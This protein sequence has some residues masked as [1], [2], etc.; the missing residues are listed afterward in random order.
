MSVSPATV[1]TTIGQEITVQ[2]I[3]NTG[4]VTSRGATVALQ[5]NPAIVQVDSV[6]VGTFY[7]NW[8]AA[9]GASTLEF[10][11]PT[12][13]NVHGTV[14]DLGI[15]VIGGP[16]GVG[17]GGSGSLATYT[18]HAIANGSTALTLND[19]AIT[20]PSGQVI[21]DT[22]VINGVVWAG[23]TPTATLTPTH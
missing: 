18:M 10:P 16:S 1:N 14:S 15:S 21:P 7:A 13:D 23:V 6:A 22:A 20:Y 9:N 8:A 3:V 11:S 12:I 2:A 5:F 19:V 4:N 17:A